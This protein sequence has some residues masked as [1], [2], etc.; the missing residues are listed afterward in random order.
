MTDNQQ[1]QIDM[2]RQELAEG[3]RRD[4]VYHSL[5]RYAAQN[6][7]DRYT[8]WQAVQEVR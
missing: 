3:A 7:L 8:L 1:E 2:A 6:G 4:D 5:V